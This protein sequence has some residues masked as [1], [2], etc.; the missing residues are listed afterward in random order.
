MSGFRRLPGPIDRF[1]LPITRLQLAAKPQQRIALLGLAGG[2]LAGAALWFRSSNLVKELTWRRASL[3][4]LQ[5]AV[6]QHPDDAV[7]RY[8]L[9]ERLREAG[10]TGEARA[11]YSAA[12]RIDPDSARAHLA[13][14]EL[15]RQLGELDGAQT[16]LEAAARLAPDSAQA[17]IELGKLYWDQLNVADAAAQFQRTAALDPRSPRPWY[18]LAVC[19]ARTQRIKLA[20]SAARRSVALGGG[21]RCR[22]ALG[23]LL[24]Y[25]GDPAEAK[26]TLESAVKADPRYGPALAL[27]GRWLFL[28]STF[29]SDHTRAERLLE[30]AARVPA[31]EPGQIYS[32]LGQI[33][34]SEGKLDRAAAALENAMLLAPNDEPACYALM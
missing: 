18:R 11:A 34:A 5:Q 1:H 27:L 30:K 2:L 28:F 33:Y 23:E 19:Y 21:A 3:A 26:S 16:N 6:A 25:R 17:H 8:Y 20:I 22:T 12:L 10:R 9:A 7:A 29:P 32:A 15:L 13:L 24:P 31:T 14:G 4:G